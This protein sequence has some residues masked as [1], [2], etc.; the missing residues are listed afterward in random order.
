MLIF[1]IQFQ[2]ISLRVCGEAAFLVPAPA[3]AA[4]GVLEAGGEEGGLLVVRRVGP[5]E[6]DQLNDGDD[7]GNQEQD[8]EQGERRICVGGKEEK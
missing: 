2:R 6:D 1:R 3:A 4:K 8:N 5:D 7:Q